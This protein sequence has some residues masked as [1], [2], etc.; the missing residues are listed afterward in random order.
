MI[1]TGW[2][3][4]GCAALA[5]F[6]SG[7]MVTESTYLKKVEEAG[8]LE[9]S[10]A[11]CE[12]KAGEQAARIAALEK[13]QAELAAQ[14]E[15]QKKKVVEVQAVKE[16]TSKAYSAMIEKMK[17]EIAEGQV[18]ITE[19]QGRLTVNMVDAILFDSGKADIKPEG[20]QV[21]QKVA[22]VINQV[23]DKAIRVE[24]HTDNVKISPALARAFPSNWELSAARAVNVARYL[25]RL[26]VDPALL[27]AVAYGEFRPV[28]E[29][30]TPEG[31]A[32]NRRIEI[33][34]VPRD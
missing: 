26:G 9:K 1:R 2:L 20:R 19:L 33:V 15:E 22:E 28:S 27:S 12:Q 3:A 4:V 10:L 6:V 16:E 14:L 31:R 25:Q 7:C 5:L 18:T 30:D 11:A 24:G 21:L 34:L 17:A 29:N 13:Q 8:S 32:R 23:E